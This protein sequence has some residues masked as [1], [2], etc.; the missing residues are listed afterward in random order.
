VRPRALPP[1]PRSPAGAK[2]ADDPRRAGDARFNDEM[3]RIMTDAAN[4]RAELDSAR[5]GEDGRLARLETAAVAD[6][7]RNQ[8]RGTPRSR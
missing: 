5:S 4:T 7:I 6:L 3:T 2:P 8:A 1:N